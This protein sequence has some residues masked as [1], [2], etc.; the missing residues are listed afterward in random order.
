MGRDLLK[1]GEEKEEEEGIEVNG[2]ESG[3]SAFFS[4]SI[5][6]TDFAIW[7][8][9]GVAEVVE[10]EDSAGS[11]GGGVPR[12]FPMLNLEVLRSAFE[13]YAF[14]S[15]GFVDSVRGVDLALILFLPDFFPRE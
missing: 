13:G 11:R 14:V 12:W 6:E 2:A 8:N 1:G 3:R 5:V 10:G 7:R 15:T 9:V 4:P